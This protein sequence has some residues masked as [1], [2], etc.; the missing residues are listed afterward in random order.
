MCTILF[1]LCTI[2]VG[3][4]LQQLL[5]AFVY[6]PADVPD[7]STT[8]WLDYTTTLCVLKNNLYATVVRN[9]LVLVCRSYAQDNS[10]VACPI[11]YFSKFNMAITMWVLRRTLVIDEIWRLYVV[12]MCGCGVVIIPVGSRSSKSSVVFTECLAGHISSWLRGFVNSPLYLMRSPTSCQ[13]PLM[14]P[15]PYSRSRTMGCMVQ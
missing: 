12:F 5:D 9:T 3:A 14:Q 6:A 10:K 13:V 15:Q 11:H 7:Y 1:L 2:H 4:S 8:Y